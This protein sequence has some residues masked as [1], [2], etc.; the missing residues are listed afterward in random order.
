MTIRIMS[1]IIVSGVGPGM[2]CSIVRL[3]KKNGNEV[4][5][6]SRGEQGKKIAGELGVGYRKCDLMDQKSTEEAFADLAKS[7]GGLDS[8]VHAAG[9]FFTIRKLAS[10]DENLF[11]SALLNNAVTLYN[12]LKVSS[13][14]FPDSG[15]S[16]V[17]ISAARNVY[18]NSHAGYAAGKGAIEYMIRALANEFVE[19]NIR[20][21][22]VA[23]GFVA[24]EDCGSQKSPDRLGIAI[25][26]DASYVAE[27]VVSLLYNH[28]ITGQVLEVDAG[29]STMIPSG[30][31]K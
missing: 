22:A 30:S 15:G 24:K 2:G 9:G 6:I 14:L 21:N 16:I 28:M 8:V 29:F 5:V 10:V 3:L 23:P 17:A 25:R 18:M 19:R 31:E 20:L 1:R 12:V 4:S 26:H 11:K 13:G 7:M 27:A